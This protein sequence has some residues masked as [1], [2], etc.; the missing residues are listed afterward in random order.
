[1]VPKPEGSGHLSLFPRRDAADRFPISRNSSACSCRS[2]SGSRRPRGKTFFRGSIPSLD[3][4]AG[5][6][7]TH[8]EH[9]DVEKEFHDRVPRNFVFHEQH[10]PIGP[11][12]PF[13]FQQGLLPGF[14]LQFIEGM[15][16]GH[17]VGDLSLPQKEELQPS[18]STKRTLP[19]TFFS[20][21]L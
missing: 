6:I 16:T 21:A 19:V 1:M 13:H 12:H 11:H 17:H 2:S 9:P 4:F 18:P 8:G 10:D 7:R 14:P 20:M 3:E 5:V 15:G